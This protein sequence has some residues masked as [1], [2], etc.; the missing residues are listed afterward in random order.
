[1]KTEYAVQ[2]YDPTT[3]ETTTVVFPSS[4]EAE[5]EWASG[6]VSDLIGIRFWEGA[7]WAMV[8]MKAAKIRRILR[9]K[10]VPEELIPGLVIDLGS[11]IE[12]ENDE[13]RSN[14]RVTW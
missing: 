3:R 9:E 11:L 8:D 7:Q 2:R 5:K 4:E 1:M 13:V 12:E 6:K 10:G 14:A